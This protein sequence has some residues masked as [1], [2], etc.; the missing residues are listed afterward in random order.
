MK[1]KIETPWIA[2]DALLKWAQVVSSGGEA[3]MLISTGQVFV[4]GQRVLERKKK[5]Y[6]HDVVTIAGY[7]EPIEVIG[8]NS[9]DL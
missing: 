3:K 2:L 5:I 8:E 7:A 1:Q 6:P 4:Q 9:G